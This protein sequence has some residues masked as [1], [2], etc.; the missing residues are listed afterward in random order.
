MLTIIYGDTE[1]SIYNSSNQLEKNLLK[2]LLLYPV[3]R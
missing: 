2:V 3:R 1:N